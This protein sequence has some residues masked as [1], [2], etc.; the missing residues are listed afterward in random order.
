VLL[1]LFLAQV[2]SLVTIPDMRVVQARLAGLSK[3]WTWG[4]AGLLVFAPYGWWLARREAGVRMLAA[5]LAVTFFGYFLVPFDQGHGWGYRYIHS[6]WF[7]LPVF[8]ALALT[9]VDDGDFRAM[10]AWALALSLFLANGLRIVQV[11]GFVAHHLEQVPPLTRAVEK[12]IIFID[13]TKGFYTQ[14]LVQNDPLLRSPR[15][16]MVYRDAETTAR[17]MARRFPSYEK[18]ESGRWGERWSARVN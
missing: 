18:R 14:D 3:M 1:D 17:F 2:S 8:A 13:L 4:A 5:A 11:E 15:M 6:A 16:I 12:E 7:V 10:A 9:R